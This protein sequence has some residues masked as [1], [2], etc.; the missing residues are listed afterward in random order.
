MKPKPTFILSA[1]LVAIT[2]FSLRTSAQK[3]GDSVVFSFKS[4][5]QFWTVP[6]GAGS[7]HAEIYG[8]QGGS[9][10]GGKGGHV[11]A[12][13]SLQPGTK[14]I[15]YVG[16]QPGGAE[17]GVNGGGKGCGKGTGGGGASDI[18]LDG[19]DLSKRILVA[20][21]G[22]GAGYDGTG[23]AGGGLIGRE[24][25]YFDGSAAHIAKGGT[26]EAGGSGARAYYA[27]AGTIGQGGEGI[28]FNGQCT[29]GAMGGGGGGYYGGGGSGAG[30]GGGG[31]SY[32]DA[33]LARNVVHHQGITEGNGRIVLYWNK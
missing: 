11:A 23:G 16:G 31:S 17:E 15:L 30:G 8:A 26:Q 21:G 9:A 22:G 14:L 4:G 25:G 24:S 12:D 5:P 19:N 28:N 1:F 32:A 6:V 29:N 3:T 33:Q 10:R 27:K 18:R 2:F 20:G 13:L 7:V